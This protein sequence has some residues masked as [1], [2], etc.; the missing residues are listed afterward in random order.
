MQEGMLLEL[1][2][3]PIMLKPTVKIDDVQLYGSSSL[4]KNY[5]RAISKSETASFVSD[6]ISKLVSSGRI[7]VCYLNKGI[8][9]VLLWKV[10]AVHPF[11][12]V[13]AFFHLKTGKVYVIIDN[14]ISIFGHISDQLLGRLTIHESCHMSC[15]ANYSG[16][17][18]LFSQDLL[19]YYSNY[20][21]SLFSL[22]DIPEKSLKSFIFSL[23]K[24]ESQKDRSSKVLTIIGE[25][26]DSLK[27][28]LKGSSEDFDKIRD[29]YIIVCKAMLGAWDNRAFRDIMDSKEI[30]APLYKSYR[31]TFG[32]RTSNILHCQ[33]VVIP[34]EVVCVYTQVAPKEK[35]ISMLA[36]IK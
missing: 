31:T 35:I 19:N 8:I 7:N 18:N 12:S 2:S 20:F 26:L 11:R 23:I 15:N 10:L 1:F 34:S 9:R 24:S 25:F 27:K 13:L 6:Q 29:R 30:I 33:E 32:L 17:F 4:D 14:N 28:G 3:V 16:F 21:K 5:K 22:S 36:L